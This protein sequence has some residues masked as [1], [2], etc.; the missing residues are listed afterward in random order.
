MENWIIPCNIK[1]FDIQEHFKNSNKVVWKNDSSIKMGDCAYL[2]L[3]APMSQIKYK[4]T[5]LDADVSEEVINS[6]TYAIRGDDKY[7]K[8]QRYML[9]ELVEEFDD[10]KFPF[11]TLRE[12]G[13][14]Q[15]QKQAR[16]D[17]SLRAYLTAMGA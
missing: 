7:K 6:N 5:V 1:F 11:S 3:G 13:L 15:V 8:R 2:Y 10:G 9:L 4:C 12:K 16:V 14:G 17:R